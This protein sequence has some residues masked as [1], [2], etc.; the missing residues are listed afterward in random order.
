MVL[1]GSRGLQGLIGAQGVLR[2]LQGVPR[3]SSGVQEVF[4]GFS[5]LH[6]G[7]GG[8]QGCK[9]SSEGFQRSL[10]PRGPQ[11][12]CRGFQSTSGVQEGLQGA[13]FVVSRSYWGVGVFR[14]MTR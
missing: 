10:E 7:P 11:R 5:G 9:G 8:P 1:R 14:G 6:W 13:L 3:G 4:R 2:G 12:G